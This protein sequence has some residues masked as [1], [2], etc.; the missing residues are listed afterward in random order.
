MTTTVIHQQRHS[1]RF[2]VTG[3]LAALLLIQGCV[4]FRPTAGIGEVIEWS[5][6]RGWNQ[7]RH[8]QAWSALQQSCVRLASRDT[9]WERI[10]LHAADL[11]SPDDD[12]ARRFFQTHFTPHRVYGKT[13]RQ[14]ALF[15]GYY[16]P[17]LHGSLEPSARYRY[18]L[19]AQPDD[20]LTIDLRDLYPELEGKRIRGRVLG[21]RVVPYY[22]R[23]EL[24][25]NAALLSGNELLW[26]DDE[27]ALFFLHVQGS[28]R[29]RMTDG[30]VL[31]VGY[32]DQ[33]GHPYVAI[34]KT[35][36][37]L[38]ELSLDEVSL[39]SIRD[40]LR[41]HP[42]RVRSILHSNPS[43]VFFTARQFDSGGPIGA[44]Q[45]PLSAGRSIAVDP[46]VI[47][48]GTPVWI[49]TRYPG[50]QRRLQRLLM[51]QDT[52]GAIR[53]PLR[54]DIFWGHGDDAEQLAGNMKQSGE[55]IVLLPKRVND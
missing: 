43:Y 36:V 18:P 15:T 23:Q 2:G 5:K 41:S 50:D 1:L 54:A 55:I 20:L 12:T 29:V 22:S 34:G 35:L 45:V 33:N 24:D 9:N 8:S 10:C 52:G 14:Q 49:D 26:V 44:F 11:L 21:R 27:T 38:G 47:P 46:A 31:K 3:L 51:A 40:W 19:Y 30:G 39:F 16:E 28:G 32:V 53:G 13:R 4:L 6:V 25:D 37:E 48:L 7:D 42:E 17:L